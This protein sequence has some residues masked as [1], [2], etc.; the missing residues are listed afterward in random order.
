MT[1]AR[2]ALEQELR[3]NEKEFAVLVTDELE[4]RFAR[5]EG[6]TLAAVS[7]LGGSPRGGTGPPESPA[8]ASSA[9]T[10]AAM[11]TPG[12]YATSITTPTGA[13]CLNS[14][15]CA[16]LRS[17]GPAQG[18]TCHPWLMCPRWLSSEIV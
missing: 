14:R 1:D 2:N 7:K 16:Q 5:F 4:Q 12:P 15:L 10:C 17:L 9:L 6:V 11:H 3:H 13:T 8:S 18:D